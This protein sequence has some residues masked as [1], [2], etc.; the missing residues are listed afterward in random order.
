ML[1]NDPGELTHP[2]KRKWLPV[3]E[4]PELHRNAMPLPARSST[5]ANPKGLIKVLDIGLHASRPR[6]GAMHH[7]L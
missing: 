3:G 4:Y 6:I 5:V 1:Q 7:S 2:Y